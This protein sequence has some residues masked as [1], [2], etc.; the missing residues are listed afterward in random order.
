VLIKLGSAQTSIDLLPQNLIMRLNIFTALGMILY[1]GSFFM[2]NIL[3]GR[4]KLNMLY[5]LIIGLG[6]ILMLLLSR[7]VLKEKMSFVQAVGALVTLLGLVIMNI[8]VTARG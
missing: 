1:I 7:M 8:K 3:V 4:Y 6:Y 2:F 5:P